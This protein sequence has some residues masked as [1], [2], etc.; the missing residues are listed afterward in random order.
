MKRLVW[1]C[2]RID[3]GDPLKL[4][5]NSPRPLNTKLFSLTTPENETILTGPQKE[6]YFV[7]GTLKQQSYLLTGAI[8]HK[9]I[10]GVEG[11]CVCGG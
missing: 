2:P 1:V 6:N 9:D 4:R 8:K 7:I 10:L 3:F 5:Q 11:V